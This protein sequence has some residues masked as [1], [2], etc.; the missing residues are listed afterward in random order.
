MFKDVEY[1][2]CVSVDNPFIKCCDEE[3][4]NFAHDNHL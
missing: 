1:I 4:I 3:M 2:H